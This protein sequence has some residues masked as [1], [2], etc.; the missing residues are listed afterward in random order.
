MN[1]PNSLTLARIVLV[2]LLVVVLLTSFQGH[3]VLGLPKGMAAALIFGVASLTDWLDGYLA[4]RRKQITVLGQLLDPIADKLLTTAAFVSLVQLDMVQAWIVAIVIGRELAVTGLRGVAHTRGLVMPASGLGKLKMVAQ[5]V[6]ILALMLASDLAGEP[7]RW[8]HLLG[9]GAMWVV[10][11][12]ALWSAVEYYQTFAAVVSGRT[13]PASDT[14]D[15][16]DPDR[17]IPLTGTAR[18]SAASA[19]APS[20][21]AAPAS[22]PSSAPSPSVS[23]SAASVSATSVSSVSGALASRGRS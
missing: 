17:P 19:S 3:L 14:D 16:P 9:L 22:A 5:V 13:V 7:G 10:L 23:P 2:P 6:A 4:R 11:G 20:P 15:E 21:S 12:L 18:T 8:L 1:L